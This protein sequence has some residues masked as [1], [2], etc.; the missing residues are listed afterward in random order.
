MSS[1][2]KNDPLYSIY[3][4]WYMLYQTVKFLCMEYWLIK[5]NYNNNNNVVIK[6]LR[7]VLTC[8]VIFIYTRCLP[9]SLR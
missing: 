7:T 3:K 9:S 6:L 2:P 8:Q 4:Y 5:D 1:T